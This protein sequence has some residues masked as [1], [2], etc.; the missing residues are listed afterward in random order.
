MVFNC[1]LCGMGPRATILFVGL[2]SIAFAGAYTFFTVSGILAHTCS[3]NMT[4]S[5]EMYAI[6]LFYLRSSECGNINLTHLGLPGSIAE[7]QVDV[8]DVAAAAQRTYIFC[9]IGVVL[10]GLWMITSF[11]MLGSACTPCMSRCCIAMGI[12]PYTITLFLVL[13]FS[14]VTFVFYLIDFIGSFDMY[15]VMD[16]LEIQNQEVVRYAFEQIESIYLIV[17]S[18]LL[19]LTASFGVILW[20]MFLILAFVMLG[21]ASRLWNENKPAPSYNNVTQ[22]PRTMMVPAP[23]PNEMRE[24][25]RP[26]SIN[27]TVTAARY[28]DTA[29]QPNDILPYREVSPSNVNVRR[30]VEPLKSGHELPPDHEANN[31][32]NAPPSPLRPN[33][34]INPYT[35]KRFT[36]LPGNP[37]PF[38]Y[39]AG[40]PQISPRN[41][42][43]VPTEVRGQLPWSY[44]KGVP[45]QGP[46]PR[47]ATSTLSDHKEFPGEEYRSPMTKPTAPDDRSSDEGKWS[48]PEYRY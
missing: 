20:F 1:T 4:R 23:A 42:A 46:V 18:L 12:I 8:P 15:F 45:D 39:L 38:S 48:G 33:T 27:L 30:T 37:Q 40:P 16:L 25:P 35:D 5:P 28:D 2:V 21:T 31:Y 11:I 17:P 7:V 44:F 29:R 24:E 22:A 34:M 36:Y 10:F 19:W 14:A 26:P 3:I 6:Y 43:N 9:I 47:R 41:S 13:T 32:P